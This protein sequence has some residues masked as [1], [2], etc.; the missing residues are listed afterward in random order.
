MASL[1]EAGI[2]FIHTD[3]DAFWLQDPLPLLNKIDADLV[4]SMDMGIPA[5]VRERWGF[6]LCCGFFRLRSTPA[7]RKFFQAWQQRTSQLGDDQIA[8]NELLSAQ[9]LTW[10]HLPGMPQGVL[11]ASCVLGQKVLRIAVLPLALLP[12]V[13][14]FYAQ[15]ALLAHPWFERP[16]FAAYLDLLARV[17]DRFG[18]LDPA[19]EVAQDAPPELDECSAATWRMLGVILAEEIAAPCLLLRGA[20]YGRAGMPLEAL[21]DFRLA[22]ARLGWN[23]GLRVLMAEALLLTGDRRQAA[24]VLWPI[25]RDRMVELPVLRTSTMLMRR[26]RGALQAVF[27]LARALVHWRGRAFGFLLAWLRRRWSV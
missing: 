16:L 6:T 25:A 18:R 14:P 20:M 10:E 23:S 11:Q 8:L 24:D 9:D 21:E 17:M 2:D 26:A 19:P 22:Q 5:H 15:G 7:S 27:F 13:V 3:L 1:L 12:R 4:F